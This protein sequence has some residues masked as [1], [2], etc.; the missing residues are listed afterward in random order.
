MLDNAQYRMPE[1]PLPPV[2]SSTPVG[3]DLDVRFRADPN[4]DGD[5]I[6]IEFRSDKNSRLDLAV[7]PIHLQRFPK[8][9]AAYKEGRDQATGGTSLDTVTWIDADTAEMLRS[10][11][12]FTVEQL[13]GLHDSA[14][15]QA[16]N[17]GYGNLRENAIRHLEHV[18]TVS[19]YDRLAEQNA[20]LMAE[21][22]ELRELKERT[23]KLEAAQAAQTPK[24][25][26]Q[27]KK[28]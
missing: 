27:A 8:E 5:R 3:N 25:R 22:K 24:P 20:T 19:G 18:R 12:I 10:N 16:G 21:L 2:F 7:K 23:A 28:G 9:W 17:S 4:R 11:R 6:I 26:L 1:G 15:E 13:A 14:I